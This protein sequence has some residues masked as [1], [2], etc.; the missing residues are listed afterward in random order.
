MVR[1]TLTET[2]SPPVIGDHLALDLLNTE[3]RLDGR[4]V[5]LWRNGDD[6]LAWL[7]GHPDAPAIAQRQA[8]DRDHLIEA[9][10]ALRAEARVLVQRFK[11]GAPID[12]GALNAVL[13][14]YRTTTR[15][16]HDGNGRLVLARVPQCDPVAAV[17]GPV[18]EA[19]ATLL[20]QGDPA[21]VKRCESPACVFWFYDRTKAR[22]RRWCSMALCGNRHKAAR[23]RERHGGQATARQTAG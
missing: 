13:D 5:D 22:R 20:A 3:V 11:E 14:A 23:F 6:V 19:V 9:A 10:R 18:A 2:S 8:I 7:S 17:L 15:L 16:A 4:L 21:L 1:T 12:P